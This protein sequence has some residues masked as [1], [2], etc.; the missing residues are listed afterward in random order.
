M[1]TAPTTSP[2][3]AT[4]A[5]LRRVLEW[6]MDNDP[7]TLQVVLG[8]SEIGMG[9]DRCLVHAL[10]GHGTAADSGS[11]LPT[12]GKAVHTWLSGAIL[13]HWVAQPEDTPRR[14]LT[15][16]RV[17]VGTITGY[18]QISGELDLF[19]TLTG[20]VVDYKIVGK[21][22]LDKVRRRGASTTYQRQVQAYAAGLAAQ[23]YDVRAVAV[24]FLPR[25]GTNLGHGTLWTAPYDPAVT[26]QTLARAN[27]LWAGV[28]ALGVEAVLTQLPPHTGEEF[29]CG[30][31]PGETTVAD[32]ISDQLNGILPAPQTPG[33]TGAGS[34]AHTR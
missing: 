14:W 7:R 26:E 11:W 34:T 6:A 15:D 16:H 3:Q 1:T 4:I 24:W 8:P 30:R 23:G 10:A 12:I 21:T 18:G 29:T 22:T 31:W 9:C 19:D 13:R 32:L 5:D 20:T 28:Q 2:A 17:T 25:N 33:T 27:A